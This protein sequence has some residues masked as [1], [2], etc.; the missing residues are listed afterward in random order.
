MSYYLELTG[1]VLEGAI[2]LTVPLALL[3]GMAIWI[4]SLG[5]GLGVI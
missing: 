2:L 4:L 1:I 5:R 3:A